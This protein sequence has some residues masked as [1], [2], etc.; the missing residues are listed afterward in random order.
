MKS[1]LRPFPFPLSRK[2]WFYLVVL[3]CLGAGLVTGSIN[4]G[5]AYALYHSQT[6]I[7]MWILAQNTVAGE[8]GVSPIINGI[9][10]IIIT[11]TLVHTDLHH[12]MIQPLSF[13]YP[14][15]DHLPDPRLF[16]KRRVEPGKKGFRYYFAMLMR[17]IF[18]GTERNMLLKRLP[19]KEWVINLLWTGVQGAGVGV[20]VGFPLWCITMII[21]A[22]I[23]KTNQIEA[24]WAPE[25]ING[26]YG[27][28]LGVLGNPIFALMAL[29]SQ[30]EHH[31]IV[32]TDARVDI[33]L[34]EGVHVTTPPTPAVDLNESHL[35][36]LSA[37]NTPKRPRPRGAS[38][39]SF[40][41]GGTG[42]R[43]QRTRRYSSAVRP[44]VPDVGTFGH[45]VAPERKSM[46]RRVSAPPAVWD[47]FGEK[48]EV[49]EKR[50]V[51]ES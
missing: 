9:A 12:N 2:Q 33:A 23:F 37:L 31:L 45:L 32:V 35:S 22:P 24:K 49:G 11:S 13:V 6:K 42:G 46:E 20:I 48:K 43:A 14:H 3:Q 27:F 34:E 21:I 44:P 28:F 30:A 41:L 39:S 29:G 5:V 38:T 26:I 51:E 50:G 18:E 16:F 7:T 1:F 17:F 40:S 25:Y 10:T 8:L 4:F 36:T 19:F 15:V 47:V